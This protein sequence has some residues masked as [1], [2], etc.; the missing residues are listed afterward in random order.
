MEY[1]WVVV[2]PDG[3]CAAFT[4]LWIDT[5][6]RSLLFEP[7]GTHS[8]YRRLGIAKA[9]MVHALWLM[10]AEHGIKCAYVGHEPPTKNP[11]SG[12]LYAAVGFRKLHDIYDYAKPVASVA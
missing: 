1:E 5:V 6:N 10:Q 11:A 2:A 7:V 4:N 12:A 8:D 3:R 9:M